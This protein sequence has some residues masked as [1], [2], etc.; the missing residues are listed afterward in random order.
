MLASLR[1]PN[2]CLFLGASLKPPKRAI[3]TELVPRGSLWDVLRQPL[4][5][6]V[7][8][9]T[10]GPPPPD[11]PWPLHLIY[12]VI[13]TIMIGRGFGGWSYLLPNNGCWACLTLMYGP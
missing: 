4:P 7:M 3:I 2:I 5:P 1:H 9:Y 13:I 6:G 11:T 8:G 10:R 12:K